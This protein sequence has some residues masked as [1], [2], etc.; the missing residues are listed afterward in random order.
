MRSLNWALL[1]Y[2]VLK[3][4]GNLDTHTHTHTHTHT[5]GTQCKDSCVLT[6]VKTGVYICKP[7]FTDNYKKLEEGRDDFPPDLSG[8]MALPTA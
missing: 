8:N 6:E 7:R 2:G 3:R 5:E 4:R 1:H